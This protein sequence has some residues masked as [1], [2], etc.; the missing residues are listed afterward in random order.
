MATKNELTFDRLTARISGIEKQMAYATSVALNETAKDVKKGVERQLNKDID[1]P[2]P[3]TQKAFFIS[4]AKK[5]KLKAIVGIRPIQA[6]YLGKQIEGGTGDQS[7][8]IIPKLKARN[9]YGN[10]PRNKLS[11][12]KA[13]GKTFKSDGV[14]K[15][16]LKKS[17][18]DLAFVG[19]RATYKK[20][21]KF[22]ERAETTFK[23]TYARN[24]Q[25]AVRKALATAR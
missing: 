10:L 8:S 14:I 4:Y 3:F 22:F 19:K 24:M 21:F 20:R 17:V 6:K 11:K 2:T 7:F 25:Q 9:K 12:L 13:Q 23:K 18:K 15:Q 16:R 5:T 1:R